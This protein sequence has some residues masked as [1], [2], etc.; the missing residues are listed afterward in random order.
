MNNGDIKYSVI[1]PAYNAKKTISFTLEALLS[2]EGIEAGEVIVVD[3]GSSD[4]T[5]D[6]VKKYPVRLIQ[7]ANKGPASARNYGVR[8]A[9]GEIVLFTDS[10]CIPQPGWLKAMTD[11]F[12]DESVHGV[13]GI[14]I[15]KNKTH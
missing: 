12:Q 6:L 2:Q 13:K 8:E 11:P 3:D 15:N 10:D 14:Y 1:I 5:A 7:Q 4:N 9:K